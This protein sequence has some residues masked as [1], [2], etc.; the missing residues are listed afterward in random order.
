MNVLQRWL[1]QSLVGRIYWLYVTTLMLFLVAALGL[2]YRYQFQQEIVDQQMAGDMVMNVIAPAVGDSAV[3]GDYDTIGKML[4]R[5]IV[6]TRFS[7]A[8][9]FDTNGGAITSSNAPIVAI[10]APGWLRDWVHQQL[11]DVNYNIVIGGKDYG[12]LRLRFADAVIASGLWQVALYSTFAGLAALVLGVVLIR[13]PLQRWLGNFDRVRSHEPQILA[14]EIDVKALL[15]RDAPE[16]IRQTF[17]IIS[18]AAGHL[19]AQ[20]EEAAVTLNAITDGVLTTDANFCLVYCNP[21]A[22]HMLGIDPKQM[23]GQSVQSLF[24]DTFLN[25]D[26]E[27]GWKVRRMEATGPSGNRMI[28]DTTL[29]T[30]YSGNEVVSG[31]VLAC[32]DVSQQHAL[33]QQLRTELQK[34]HRA[35]DAMRNMLS[36]FEVTLD[37]GTD[38]P[39]DSEVAPLDADDL[40][41]LIVRVGSLI[42]E[43]ELGRRAL[44]NQK[45]ALDQH[46]IVSITDLQGKITYANGK[47]C[48]ISG[49]TREELLGA[50][51]RI[52][53]SGLHPAAVFDD[54]WHQ[55]SLGRVWHGELCNRNKSGNRYWVDATIVPLLDADGLPEHYIAIRT[56]ISARKAVE[57]QL[58]EQLQFVEVLLEATPTAIYLKDTARRY[59]RFNKAFETLFGIER[60][61]WIGKT[62]FELVPEDAQRMDAMDQQLLATGQVQTYEAS[63]LNRLTGVQRSGLYWKAPLRDSRGQITALVGT[64][65]DITEKN[66]LEQGLREAKRSAEQANEAK[67]HFL[68]NMSHE[69]RTPMNGVIGMTDLALD[70]DLNPVQREYLNIVRNSAQSLMVILNDILDFSK[71][72]AGKLHIEA[73]AFSLRTLFNESLK[74]L[75]ARAEAKNLTL[76]CRIPENVPDDW[77]GDP[78]RIRQVLTNMCDNAIKF[79]ARGSVDV[80]VQVAAGNG[81]TPSLQVSIRDSGIGIPPEKQL[82][83][84]EA[85]SQA[86]AS[87]TRKYGGTGLGL[88]ICARLVELMGG[89]IWLESKPGHGSTFY[90]TLALQSAVTPSAQVVDPEKVQSVENAMSASNAA[91]QPPAPLRSVLLV[92]DHPINQ[93]LARTLLEKWGHR[94]VLAN[95]GQ[96]AVDL[97]PTQA[98]DIIL[99][100]MQM[101]V[102]GGL[103]A[104]RCIRVLEGGGRKTPIIAMTANAMES[105]R[106]A[107]LDAGMDDYLSKPFNAQSLRAVLERHL[108]SA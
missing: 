9:F 89:R 52:V 70:T 19:S 2:F 86:D 1:P 10:E 51:H 41:A 24:P 44:N 4:D 42:E 47:F 36:S 73:T 74:S 57:V 93:M 3:I 80:E 6:G 106:Q 81:P 65:L 82:G 30:I 29:S 18:R 5:A 50:N 21:A 62:V 72:E 20:R 54:M 33:D 100:D 8:R 87:T 59:L 16:E 67:S 102:M 96:E 31:H 34:R 108:K 63:F 66:L 95:H 45:F 17:D 53:N 98:W 71:I 105:D 46:A 75:N 90:F 38:S 13:I 39:S 103:E 58:A 35:L 28:L 23:V 88:T 22:Q 12:V 104:T 85:F 55:I 43:R 77:I 37:I 40:D 14:G 11:F 61:N 56:D 99:M 32:R 49:Y 27:L 7:E 94:V 15:D 64:I 84:F 68:A 48:E 83:I 79:T 26:N 60:E 92:E 107:C 91:S 97:F 69:I 101:P 76:G 78:V 25:A